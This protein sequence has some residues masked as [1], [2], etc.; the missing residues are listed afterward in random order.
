[1][2]IT[3]GIRQNVPRAQI[4][5]RGLVGRCPNCGNRS[6]FA[7]R[8]LRIR[9]ACPICELVFDPGGGFWLGPL[10]INYCT[11]VFVVV[12]PLIVL[13]VR[14]IIPLRLAIALAVLVGGVAV[15]LLLYR[16]SWS[17]WLMIYFFFFPH[18]LPENF[19]H[20]GVHLR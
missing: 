5:E 11:S 7:P 9:E 2:Q 6:L 12:C 19:A 8:S 4:I 13:G 15:P 3:A 17:W 1:M 20:G 16:L 18:R 14:E 10:V